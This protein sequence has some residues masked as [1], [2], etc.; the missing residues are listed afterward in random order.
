MANYPERT[1]SS[2]GMAN[3]RGANLSRRTSRTLTNLQERTLLRVA[4]VQAEGYVAVEKTKE[5]DRVAREAMSGQAMLRKWADVLSTGDP[6]IAADLLFFTDMAK[7]GK[8]EIIADTVDSF[9][10][11]GRR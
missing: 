3:V 8:G 7:L 1:S 2:L 9:C 6:T 4:D 5:I 11:E 10:R